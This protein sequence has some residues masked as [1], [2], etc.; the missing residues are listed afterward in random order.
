MHLRCGLLF[1][2]LL[3]L[4]SISV[5]QDFG[6]MES[7]ETVNQGNIKL[8]AY[9]VFVFQHEADNETGLA[10]LAGWLLIYLSLAFCVSRAER[11]GRAVQ[12][13]LSA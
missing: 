4:P 12:Q 13:S 1:T 11:K 3:L 5:A 7:A 8:G 10:L 2:L 6:V 9:P